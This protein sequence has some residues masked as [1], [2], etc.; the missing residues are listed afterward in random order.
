LI[1]TLKKIWRRQRLTSVLNWEEMD[2]DEDEDE[3]DGDDDSDDDNS[4][5]PE[6]AREKVNCVRSTN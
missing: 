1:R 3:E 2:D 6:L 5:D 4:I